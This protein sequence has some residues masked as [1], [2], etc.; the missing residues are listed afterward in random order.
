VLS[1]NKRTQKNLR[2]EKINFRGGKKILF[3]TRHEL[4]YAVAERCSGVAKEGRGEAV[5]LWRQFYGGGTMGYAA[6][7]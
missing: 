2:Y 4:D 1:R 3:I 7:G 6:V 5:R